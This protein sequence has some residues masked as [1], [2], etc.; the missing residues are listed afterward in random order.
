MKCEYFVLLKIYLLLEIV[1]VYTIV[2]SL[3][4]SYMQMEFLEGKSY[5]TENLLR[6]V[7]CIICIFCCSLN[8]TITNFSNRT[9]E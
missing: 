3:Y 9:Y 6:H 2:S 8:Q 5:F 1:K 7:R 4:N